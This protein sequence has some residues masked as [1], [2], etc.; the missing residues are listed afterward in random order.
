MKLKHLPVALALSTASVYVQAEGP[1][2]GKVYGKI[3]ASYQN[4]DESVGD[5][6]ELASNASRLGLKGKTNL[7]ENLDL[8]YQVEYEIFVDDGDKSGST[9][10]QRNTF[11]G[12]SGNYGTAIAGKHDTPLKLAQGKVDLFNDLYGDIK[13]L[14]RGEVR[15]DNIVMYSSPEM[16]GL[17]GKLAIVPGEDPSDEDLNGPADAV[18]ASVGYEFGDGSVV[19]AVDSEVDGYDSTRLVGTYKIANVKLGLLWQDSEDATGVG[20]SEDGIVAS[21]A[22]GISADNTVKVQYGQ[23]DMKVQGGKQASIGFD[24]KLSKNAK[25][26]A[27]YTDFSADAAADESSAAGVGAE[28]KF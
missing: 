1:I 25:I 20:D 28:L 24:H 12:V 7:S 22:I 18:S 16:N 19:L 10:S 15:A 27:F 6:W 4:V 23:S 17:S 13:N 2:D 26:Y 8:I 14:I 3:N 21:A 5:A 9:L 11:L